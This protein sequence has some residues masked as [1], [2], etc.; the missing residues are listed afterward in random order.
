MTH[1]LILF[2]SLFFSEEAGDDLGDGA[3]ACDVAGGAEAVHGYVEG[4][5][6][7]VVGVGESED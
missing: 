6:H 1:P 7:G 2:S 4:Y 5:H 3:V